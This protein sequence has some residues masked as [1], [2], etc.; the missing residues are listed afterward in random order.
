MEFKQETNV[1]TFGIYVPPEVDL[2]ETG[3]EVNLLK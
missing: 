1:R 3:D 2:M